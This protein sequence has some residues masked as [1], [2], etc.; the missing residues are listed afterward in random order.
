MELESQ[1]AP[2][3]LP[4]HSLISPFCVTEANVQMNA[5]QWLEVPST[6]P[7]PVG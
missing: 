2:A 7:Q 4:H 3:P 6:Q 1:R 5:D